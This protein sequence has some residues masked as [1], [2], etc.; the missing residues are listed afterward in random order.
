[1]W[2]LLL[3]FALYHIWKC[4]CMTQDV[5]IYNNPHECPEVWWQ[6]SW[7]L[8]WSSRRLPARCVGVCSSITLFS[9]LLWTWFP[10]QWVYIKQTNI[11]S[12][13]WQLCYGL[14]TLLFVAWFFLTVSATRA[15]SYLTEE[16]VPPVVCISRSLK[17]SKAH[18]SIE[19]NLTQILLWNLKNC[20]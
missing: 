3:C 19:P 6:E 10:S 12:M 11:I 14:H 9:T 17:W 18:L 5:K 15:Y 16:S 2:V 8:V 13:F 7:T 1:M 20:E 4:T